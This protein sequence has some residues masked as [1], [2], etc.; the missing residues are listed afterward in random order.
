MTQQYDQEGI[1]LAPG[2][3]LEVFTFVDDF[4]TFSSEG[5]TNWTTNLTGSG[6][7]QG[8]KWDAIAS[9]LEIANHPG[10]LR[11][12]V[13]T[14]VGV[15]TIFQGFS[16]APQGFVFETVLQVIDLNDPGTDEHTLSVG[17]NIH[18]AT[19]AIVFLYDENSPNWQV[20]IKDGGV[21][22]NLVD[23]GILVVTREAYRLRLEADVSANGGA[24]GAVLFINGTKV[25][26]GLQISTSTSY[27][28]SISLE[29]T[30]V[31]ANAAAVKV[32]LVSMSQ[33]LSR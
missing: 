6:T 4:M 22:L 19:S 27:S 11:F 7:L 16:I 28:P 12:Q 9:I 13:G 26:T 32:D 18:S 10:T 21:S 15:A 3:P 31:S 25:L 29:R 17:L 1:N 5:D 8:G 20:Q 30:F 14:A 23:T 2:N 24:G 33:P